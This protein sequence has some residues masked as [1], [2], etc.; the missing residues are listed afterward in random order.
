MSVKL[1]LKKSELI[2]LT[3]TKQSDRSNK[4]NGIKDTSIG[5]DYG[6]DSKWNSGRWGEWKQKV[7]NQNRNRGVMSVGNCM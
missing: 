7:S 4:T 5:Y 3:Q 1:P 2:G 6:N